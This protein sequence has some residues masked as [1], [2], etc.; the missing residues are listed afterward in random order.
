MGSMPRY[1]DLLSIENGVSA[2]VLK[3]K[4][5]VVLASLREVSCCGR[6][7]RSKDA[8]DADMRSNAPAVTTA[9]FIGERGAAQ[10]I[11]PACAK[12][13]YGIILG[14]AKSTVT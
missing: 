13:L 14:S 6:R 11:A 9:S 8:V 7:N 4:R 1:G 2:R 10:N 12:N 5:P 3:M